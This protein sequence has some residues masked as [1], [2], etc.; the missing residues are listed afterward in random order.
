MDRRA[1]IATVTGS[2]IAASLVGE[3]QQSAKVPRIGYL[4]GRSAA[5]SGDLAT[6]FRRGL[7][8]LGYVDGRTI[9]I[10]YRYAEGRLERLPDLAANL[11]R[12]KV[13]VIVTAGEAAI[14]A[15]RGATSTIPIVMASAGDPV[16]SGLV[17][18]LARPGGNV[19]GLS[20]VATEAAGKRLELLKET[21]PMLSRVAVLWN[22]TNQ[23]KLPEWENAQLAARALGLTLRSVEVRAPDDF[24][25]AFSTIARERPDA[26]VTLSDA[27]TTIHRTRIAAFA[28]KRKL[29][30]IA[31]NRAY[32]ETG[33]L[34]TYGASQSD[35]FRR[36][37]IYVDKILKGAR[38]GDLPVEQPTKFE[39]VV[40]MKTA[41]ALGLTIPPAVLARADQVI[42]SAG[43]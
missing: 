6:A 16:G 31:E 34:M 26:L 18:S 40:N 36:A 13:D 30:T 42:E 41:K 14:R 17:A 24:E 4:L 9:L 20:L 15:A 23:S 8:D 12:L 27:V 19:T 43:P 3:G 25:G 33:S 21:L 35:L 22:P 32:A 38:P 29:P 10:E 28:I 39:L 7:H 2:I 11:V 1:F 5:E 37:A